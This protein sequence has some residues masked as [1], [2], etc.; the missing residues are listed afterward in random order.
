VPY[1]RPYA[2]GF[3]DFPL[4]STPIDSTALNTMDVGIKTA[5]D[6]FQSL[7]TV[8]RTAIAVPVVGQCVWDSDLRQL[9]VY[10]NATTGNAWQPIGNSIVCLS[11]TRP[12]TPFEGQVIRETDTNKELTYSGAAWVETNTWSATSGVTGV[13]NLI[14]PPAVSCLRSTT[15]SIANG[16]DTFV[17]WP[18][19]VYD[20]DGM[21][22]AGSDTVTIQT[23]GIYLIT[24]GI[25]YAANSTGYRVLAIMKNPSSATDTASCL[26]NHWGPTTTIPAVVNTSAT[27]TFAASDTIKIVAAHNAGTSLNIGSVTVPV[28][29]LSVTWVG[30]A[31]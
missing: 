3:V 9:M 16:T 25:L 10:M 20:T 4:T 6:Q 31:S 24:A 28:T 1:T 17:T 23:A 27:A 8:E 22:T 13:N 14:V 29:R 30:R 5:N 2:A 21:F 7:T 11:T 26:S 12:V 19:E 15:Q 18:I